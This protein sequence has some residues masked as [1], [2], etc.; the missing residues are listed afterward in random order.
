MYTFIIVHVNKIDTA[1]HDNCF[2]IYE[3]QPLH[4]LQIIV[5]LYEPMVKRSLTSL[6]PNSTNDTACVY[7]SVPL[8]A[9]DE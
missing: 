2:K 3:L 8:T 4:D 1:Q 5:F 9:T 7:Y 6:K